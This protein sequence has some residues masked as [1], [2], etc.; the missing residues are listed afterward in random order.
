[1]RN[2]LLCTTIPEE[3]L[4]LAWARKLTPCDR[5]HVDRFLLAPQ[6]HGLFDGNTQRISIKVSHRIKPIDVSGPASRAQVYIGVCP[7]D[8]YK[9]E[10]WS[11]EVEADGVPSRCIAWGLGQD[12]IIANNGQVQETHKMESEDVYAPDNTVCMCVLGDTVQFN[13]QS[14]ACY[15]LVASVKFTNTRLRPFVALRGQELQCSIVEAPIV[16]H[17]GELKSV[18]IYTFCASVCFCLAS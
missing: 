18:Y 2:F 3:V 8:D 17:P 13:V 12:F 14:K 5:G 1:M 16:I 10:K 11:S 7:G 15:R 4:A 6:G 9:S